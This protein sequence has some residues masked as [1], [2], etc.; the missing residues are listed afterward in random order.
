MGRMQNKSYGF[1]A[2][3][4]LSLAFVLFALSILLMLKGIATPVNT[5][6]A[7][8][9]SY[10]ISVQ[11]LYK[12]F[13]TFPFLI[14]YYPPLYHVLFDAF[15]PLF[16][17]A[18]PYVYDRILNLA[19]ATADAILLYVLCRRSFAY[20]RY[21]SLL[22]LFVFAGSFMF[23]ISIFN[24]PLFELAFDLLAVIL[25]FSKLRG[26]H[27]YAALSLAVAFLFRQSAIVLAPGIF[28]YLFLNGEKRKGI[29]F[30]AAFIVAAAVPALLLN[31]ATNGR[32]V[33][34]VFVLPFITPFILPWLL[35]LLLYFL[36]IAPSL[37]L[38]M[39]YF[40]SVY[41]GKR[42]PLFWVVVFCLL[43]VFSAGKW[44]ATNVY[45]LVPFAFLCAASAPF[46]ESLLTSSIATKFKTST[47]SILFLIVVYSLGVPILFS[48]N[49]LFQTQS[50]TAT[51]V[52]LT[53]RNFS[54]NVL[55]ESPVIALAANKPLEFD[56]TLFWTMEEHGVWNESV[57]VARVNSHGYS[58]IVFP[59]N[60]YRL[61]LYP[62]LISA[63]QNSYQLDYTVDTWQVY[64][65]KNA[66]K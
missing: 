34:S 65:P 54:G 42:S 17:N 30:L 32:Y 43:S 12:N 51:Q 31:A 41:S 10:F 44:G 40:Y 61:S 5:D 20:S 2:T 24:L 63:I 22:A 25:L 39:I 29:A 3:L 35:P 16:A 38:L 27:V 33:F 55:V 50:S 13:N 26:A 11:N 47:S 6:Y 14:S 21:S 59:A 58:A 9:Y 46:V 36:F 4:T 53:L 45:F 60:Y 64:V 19:A 48:A 57:L 49:G 56:F 18:A 52:G 8:A 1:L 62:Q 7:E 28:L 66:T 37:A 15:R 23:N